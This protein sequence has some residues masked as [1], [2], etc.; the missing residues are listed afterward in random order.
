MSIF[1]AVSI[2]APTS[3]PR[4]LTVLLIFGCPSSSCTAQIAGSPVDQ[5]GLYPPQR[6]R[7]ALRGIESDAGHPFLDEPSILPH[8]HSAAIATTG[9]Q[10]LARLAFRQA[11]V[12]VERLPGLVSQLKSNW[13]PGPLFCRMVARSIA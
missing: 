9:E 1:S 11:E 6:M 4:C 3:M 7:A 12:V 10:E 8:R 13:P 5:H 2:A